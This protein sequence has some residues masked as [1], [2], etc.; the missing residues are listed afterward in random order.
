VR[1]LAP[2]IIAVALLGVVIAAVILAPSGL[3]SRPVSSVPALL[4]EPVGILGAGLTL[5]PNG[6]GAVEFGTQEDAAVEALTELLGSPVDD[7]PQPC[8]SEDDLVRHVRWGNLVIALPEGVFTGYVITI[9]V[10]PDSPPLQVETAEGL[11]A[12]DEVADLVT[13]YGDRLEWTTLEDMGFPEPADGFGIDGYLLD[14]P[15]ATG[16][17]GFVEG[18]REEGQVVTIVAGQPCGPR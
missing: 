10:P 16:L 8:D 7:E 15:S 5:A 9:Y 3:P 2:A 4:S 6:V 13:A 14:E 11:A 1:H 12:G 17:G 18:G